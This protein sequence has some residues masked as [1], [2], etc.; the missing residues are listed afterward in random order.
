MPVNFVLLISRQGKVRLTKWYN[1]AAQKSKRARGQTVREVC[2]MVLSRPSKLCNFLDYKG[3][4]IVYKRYA[5]LFFVACVDAGDNELI[6]LE[7]IHHYVEIL[8]RYFGNVCELDIIFNFHK[9]YYVLDEL[10]INGELQE[11]SKREILRVAAE[12]D[13]LMEGGIGGDGRGT[14]KGV[15]YN[16]P[17]MGARANA[18]GRKVAAR[19]RRQLG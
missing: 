10:L 1:T 14:V 17:S 12:Q 4:K 15:V 13:D 2:A 7:I 9:A 19:V 11:T 3:T 18:M 8:D 16:R 6:T 5:S